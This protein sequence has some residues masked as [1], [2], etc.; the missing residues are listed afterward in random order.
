MPLPDFGLEINAV[1]L[2]PPSTE[3]YVL[4][5]F[6]AENE[7]PSQSIDLLRVKPKLK[8]EASKM[9]FRFENFQS[10]RILNNVPTSGMRSKSSEIERLVLGHFKSHKENICGKNLD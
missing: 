6:C 10:L 9:K 1:K 8:A 7:P 5:D 4:P 2:R 3:K